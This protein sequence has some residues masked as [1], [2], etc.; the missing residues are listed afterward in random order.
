MN[1]LSGR[2]DRLEGKFPPPARI[3]RVIRVVACQG[4]EEAARLAM[5]KG[6]DPD[7]GDILLIRLIVTPRRAARPEG[8]VT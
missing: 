2:I 8:G 6:F 7:N 1:S 3:P 5:P 4:Q